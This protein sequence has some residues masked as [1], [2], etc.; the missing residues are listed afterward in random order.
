MQVGGGVMPLS[1]TNFAAYLGS[2]AQ[3]YEGQFK[4]YYPL[5]GGWEAWAQTSVA[6]YIIQADNTID[7]LREQMIF[8][9][10]QQKVD[11]L[12]NDNEQLVTHKIAIELKCESLENRKNFASGLEADIAKL[13]DANLKENY[14]G[15]RR[16]VVGLCFTPAALQWMGTKDFKI[17]H[18]TG[19]TAIGLL[20]LN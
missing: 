3:D 10:T 4:L 16:A 6:G 15:C 9:G 1:L 19:D 7:I 17:L 12:L 13:I 20:P 5:K 18:K 14:R 8:D 11:W 2:W